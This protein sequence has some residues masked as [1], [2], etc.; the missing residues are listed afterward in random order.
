M[1]KRRSSKGGI[2]SLK[3]LFISAVAIAIYNVVQKNGV[4]TLF[5]WF[6]DWFMGIV[7]F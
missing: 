7:N 4:P 5:S 3:T 2:L 6:I 1:A